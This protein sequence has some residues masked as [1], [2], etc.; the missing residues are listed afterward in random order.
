M[1]N[2]RHGKRVDAE[3]MLLL[4]ARYVQLR[5]DELDEILDAAGILQYFAGFVQDAAGPASLPEYAPGV[6]PQPV[7]N[8]GFP[9]PGHYDG[10]GVGGSSNRIGKRARL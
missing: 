9:E 3:Q 4:L 8:R 6:P 2:H 10:V 5:T 7:L 1:L